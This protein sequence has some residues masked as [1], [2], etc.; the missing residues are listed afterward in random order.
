[1]REL[2]HAIKFPFPGYVRKSCANREESQLHQLRIVSA[3]TLMK[4]RKQR[5]HADTFYQALI[6]SLG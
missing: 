6:D 5:L 2:K 4:C 1:M 3:R